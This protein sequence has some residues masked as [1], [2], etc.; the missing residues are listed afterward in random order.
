MITNL[1]VWADVKT[2]GGRQE[3]EDVVV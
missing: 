3:D 2:P 1:M